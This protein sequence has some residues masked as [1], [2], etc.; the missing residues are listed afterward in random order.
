MILDIIGIIAIIV[1]IASV[2]A[3]LTP[4][5]SDEKWIGKAYKWTIDLCALNIGKAKELAQQKAKK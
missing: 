2:I 5:P 1:F 3:A 4:T